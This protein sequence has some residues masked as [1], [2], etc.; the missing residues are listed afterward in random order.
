MT[1]LNITHNIKYNAHAL[2]PTPMS[3]FIM[4]DS[5]GLVLSHT[6]Q[7]RRLMPLRTVEPHSSLNLSLS[8]KYEANPPWR[9]TAP[10]KGRRVQRTH[11][12][13]SQCA[14]LPSPP[15]LSFPSCLS[16]LMPQPILW[17][18]RNKQAFD[19]NSAHSSGYWEGKSLLVLETA[20]NGCERMGGF[21]RKMAMRRWQTVS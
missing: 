11:V 18:V 21:K 20:A 12:R 2:V 15:P 17:Q 14:P 5:T 10:A 9:I 1:I 8:D 3:F 7:V 16:M 13:L 4:H 6:T 19:S